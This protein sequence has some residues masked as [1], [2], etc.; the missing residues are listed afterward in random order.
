MTRRRYVI[1]AFAALLTVGIAWAG[2]AFAGRG[3]T[4]QQ[5]D[6]TRLDL[7]QIIDLP[8]TSYS[9]SVVEDRVREHPQ[10]YLDLITLGELHLSRSRETGDVDSL[11]RAQA[12]FEKALEISPDYAPAIAGLASSLYNQ[13]RFED[14]IA[15]AQR[16]APRTTAGLR[17][18]SVIADAQL[19][20]G[21]YDEAEAGYA[22][23]QRRQPGPG[24]QARLAQVEFLK[25]NPDEAI[26]LAKSAAA[27]SYFNGTDRETMAWHL[28]RVADLFFSTGDLD[29]AA[30]HYKSALDVM[31]RHYISL[32][33]LAK[34]RAAQGRLGEA[35]TL[36]RQAVDIVPQPSIVAALGDA[37]A[38]AGRR[39]DAQVQY[40]T[41]ELIGKLAAINKTVYNRELALFYADHNVHLDEALKLAQAEIEVRKDVNGYDALAWA[42]YRNGRYEEAATAIGQAL[43]LGT[44]EAAFHY[45]AGLIY[46]ALGRNA[47]ALSS[48]ET[49][50]Q[51]NPRFSLIHSDEARSV[52]ASLKSDGA[53]KIAG[54]VQK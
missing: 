45:H 22:E 31:P 53:R 20:L 11:L 38:L 15:Q 50:L 2:A 16:V 39:A 36:Y 26:R 21:R 33:G 7:R 23:L 28:S 25:G 43:S 1:L 24:M 48:L 6:L 46:K 8:Q 35:I 13:H 42:L 40:D 47:E 5:I 30:A 29:A 27:A 14:A 37:Y 9:I 3:N 32:A 52:V 49:A 44:Q 19:S 41:V 54:A 17:D 4:Q 18:L 51:I 10:S 12:A 34:V